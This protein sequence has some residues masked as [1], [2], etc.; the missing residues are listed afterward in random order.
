MPDHYCR[1]NYTIYNYGLA[2]KEQIIK[3]SLIKSWNFSEFS[4]SSIEIH[5][6]LLPEEFERICEILS[7]SKTKFILKKILLIF[8]KLSECLTVLNLCAD[9]RELKYIQFDFSEEDVKWDEKKLID[10]FRRTNGIIQKL[11]IKKHFL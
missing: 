7:S 2:I 9:C 4:V 5:L 3:N 11:K 8:S 10:N 6:K 1:Y